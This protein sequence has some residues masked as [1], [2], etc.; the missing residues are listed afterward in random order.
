ML[1]NKQDEFKWKVNRALDAVG[2]ELMEQKNTLPSLRNFH[3]RPGFNF[4]SDQ[5]QREL[6]RPATVAQKFTAAE[7]SAKLKKAFEKEGIKKIPFEFAI[8]AEGGL[9]SFDYQLMSNNFIQQ[10]QDT[11]NNMPWI[12]ILEPPGGSDLENLVP[13]QNLILIVPDMK[14][15]IFREMKWMVIG[16]IFFTLM[17]ISAFYITV[18]ALIRQK[19]LSEIKNDFIN[20]MTHEFKTPLATISLAVDALRNNKVIEDR[21]RMDYFSGIIKEENKRMNKHVETILQAALMERQEVRLDRHPLDVHALITDVASNYTLQLQDIEGRIELNLNAKNE[22][23]NGDEIHF[24]NLISNLIDNAVK[25]SKER[26]VLKICSSN[27]G[28]NLILKFE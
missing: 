7:V 27:S 2:L 6:M 8:I 18:Y 17:I 26:L 4:P 12:Y 11:I 19:K 10:S 24:R 25:Y 9:M 3:T 13:V 20:N 14:S 15:I 5:L 28:K 16:S 21:T 23:I 1:V 22:M